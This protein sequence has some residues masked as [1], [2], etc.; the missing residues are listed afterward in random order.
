[1]T[2][3]GARLLADA[4]R[5]QDEVFVSLTDDWTDDE[6]AVFERALLRLL[7]RSRSV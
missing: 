6:R 5:W 3:A 4:H 1:V 7:S 2:A